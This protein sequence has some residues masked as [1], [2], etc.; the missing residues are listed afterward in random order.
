MTKR[1][2]L[3][4]IVLLLAGAAWVWLSRPTEGSVT[5]GGIPAPRQGFLAPDFSL[6]D[7]NGQSLTLSELCGQPV[8]V[9]FWASWCPPC[10]AE[11]PALERVYQEYQ[12]KGLVLLAVNAA[13]QDSLEAAQ[14]F[15]QDNGLTFPALYDT[16]GE[17]ARLYAVRSLPSTFFIGRDGIIQ[18][19]VIGGPMAEALLRQRVERLFEGQA[20]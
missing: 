2:N 5:K 20:P 16:Q 14:A 4:L 15:M 6:Q 13:N 17:A 8:V 3:I 18:E 12:D 10:R 9:N 1:T 7:A 19:V 11:M